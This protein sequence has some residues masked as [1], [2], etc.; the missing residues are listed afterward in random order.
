MDGTLREQLT[1]IT[2]IVRGSQKPPPDTMM[3]LFRA[4]PIQSHHAR[5]FNYRRYH[6][7]CHGRYPRALKAIACISPLSHKRLPGCSPPPSRRPQSRNRQPGN[8]SPIANAASP[9]RFRSNKPTYTRYVCTKN[10]SEDGRWHLLRLPPDRKY[11]LRQLH[12]A[13]HQYLPQDMSQ[14]V[15]IQADADADADAVTNQHEK[16]EPPRKQQQLLSAP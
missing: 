14:K 13:T 9:A 7:R 12:L 1:T 4:V 8:T 2:D 11:L 5:R 6:C 10:T 3:T 16:P 15:V